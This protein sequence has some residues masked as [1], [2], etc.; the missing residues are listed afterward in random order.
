MVI[1]SKY[2]AEMVLIPSLTF[3]EGRTLLYPLP[4]FVHVYRTWHFIFKV[5][6]RESLQHLLQ[7][8]V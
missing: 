2:E 8:Y 7:K 6:S 3:T 5:Y 4:C 1:S